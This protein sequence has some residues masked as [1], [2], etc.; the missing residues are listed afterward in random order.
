MTLRMCFIGL[1]IISSAATS[2]FAGD[3]KITADDAGAYVGKEATVCGYVAS[4]NYAAN[5]KGQPT[6]L[7]LDKA[8]PRHIFTVVIFGESRKHFTSPEKSYNGKD[9]CVTGL[10]KS[11]KGKPQIIAKSPSQINLA[12]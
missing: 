11:Y 12:Q 4:T 10:I 7:N 1:L 3:L 8:F 6:F 2:G 9:I 5:S